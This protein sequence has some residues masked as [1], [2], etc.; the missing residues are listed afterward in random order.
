[1]IDHRWGDRMTFERMP[2]VMLTLLGCAAAGWASAAERAPIP[3]ADA[4]RLKTRTLCSCLFVQKFSMAQC[5][6][7]ASAIWRYPFN[8]VPALLDTDRQRVVTSLRP[9][10]ATVQFYD[11]DAAIAES[12]YIDDGGG[13]VTSAPGRDITITS[14][15]PATKVAGS[16]LPRGDLSRSID[17]KAVAAAIDQGFSATGPLAGFARAA[18]VVHEGKVVAERYAPG[19]GDHHQYYLGSVAKVF[20][21]LLAG[22]LVRQ[23]KL[24]VDERVS[25]PQ[26]QSPG[27]P[28]SRITFDH[29][30]HMTGG[31]DWTEEF[32]VAGGPGYEVYF[33]GPA[34]LDV[35][36]YVAARPAEAEPGEHFEYSTG[37]ANL[38]AHALQM[39]ID[40]PARA[41]TLEYLSR[42]L[43]GPIGAQSITPEFDAAGTL[44]AG[45]AIYAS[46]EDLA[47]VGLLLLNDGRWQGRQLLPEGWVAY[48]TKRAEKGEPAKSGYGAQLMLDM[49]G[50][51]GCFG[52]TGVGEQRLLV[53]PKRRL[54]VVWLSSAY[55]FASPVEPSADEPVRRLVLAFPE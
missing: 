25:L 22:L 3:A 1:L 38:L 37:A 31:L 48:S 41:S 43:F 45:H 23:G 35:A 26:W 29:L 30:L 9:S 24:R 46:A 7:G 52:H 12:V 27:D 49:H 11:K 8:S 18:L 13:C 28:R 40:N 53:C 19:F 2:G 4:A 21:N 16:A 10:A 6:D 39:R 47:R 14:A 34:S 50:V 51:P 32:F 44:L 17:A 55:D 33:G 15:K 36:S 54:V 42:E 5:A 20:N